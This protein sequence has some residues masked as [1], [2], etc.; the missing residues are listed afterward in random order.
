[1]S[2]K[3]AS[4]KTESS[5]KT[6][7]QMK[8]TDRLINFF[9]PQA[10]GQGDPITGFEGDRLAGLSGLQSDALGTAGGFTDVFAPQRNIPLYGEG[11]DA[12]QG[13]LSGQTGAQT[14][15]RDAVNDYFQGAI[16]DPAE[17]AF[18]ENTLPGIREA[19]AGPG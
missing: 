13:I 16:R 9:G 12:L 5:A 7:T 11:A 19:F 18:Q 14:M 15:G 10:T 1:M 3:P 6:Q 2:T 4:S 8:E 17:R